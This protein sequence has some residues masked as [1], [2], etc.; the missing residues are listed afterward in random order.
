MLTAI[1]A[2]GCNK[3]S[4][5]KKYYWSRFIERRIKVDKKYEYF[6]QEILN[7]SN[8]NINIFRVVKEIEK[9][10]LFSGS[11]RGIKNDSVSI[12]YEKK[13]LCNVNCDYYFVNIDYHSKYLEI[14]VGINNAI[15]I[16]F[17]RQLVGFELGDPAFLF[18]LDSIIKNNKVKENDCIKK[19]L[20]L[21]YTTDT[22][23]NIRAIPIPEDELF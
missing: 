13:M 19:Q 2:I 12:K 17:D 15:L 11:N 8:K 6:E 20:I 14:E 21:N 7:D 18:V 4:S 9:H 16:Y 5:N 23:T 1:I 3:D 10:I 22:S